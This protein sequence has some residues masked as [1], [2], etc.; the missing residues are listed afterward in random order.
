[1]AEIKTT[2]IWNG[3]KVDEYTD[4]DTGAMELRQSNQDEKGT[5]LAS[6]SNFEWKI[7]DSDLFLRLYNDR[8]PFTTK[9][10]KDEFDQL[11]YNMGIDLFNEDRANIL[12]DISNYNSVDEAK[13]RQT[14]FVQSTKIPGVQ[15]PVTKQVVN[16]NGT[17]TSGNPF[18]L[19]PTSNTRGGIPSNADFDLRPNV[20]P[21]LHKRLNI[22]TRGVDFSR[23]TGGGIMRYPEANLCE[24]GY[25][26]IQ[27]EG[28]EYS[29]SKRFEGG[30]GNGGGLIGDASERLGSSTG[31]VQLPMQGSLSETNSVDWGSDKLNSIMATLAGGGMEAIDRL[32]ELDLAGGV[33]AL[34]GA[35]RSAVG[36]A[37]NSDNTEYFLKAYFAGQAV[38]SNIVTRATGAVINP[39]MELLFNGPKLRDFGFSFRLT[40]RSDSEAKIIRRIIKFFKK[41][42]APSVGNQGVFLYTPNI[43]KLKYIHN[44]NGAQHPYLNKIKPCALVNFQVNYT[45]DNTYMTYE[46]GSLTSY[47]IS[48]TFSEIQ[49]IYQADIDESSDDMSY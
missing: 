35:F 16:K 19:D 45:P 27:I 12:N 30:S 18:G 41:N 7:E 17:V 31:V 22:Q 33:D 32:S 38:G 11:F 46:N 39:N 24:F 8:T 6:S 43:F 2:R 34:G 15:D 49:P 20:D 48:L 1:M 3:L 44:S 40:P 13:Q 47:N 25:D 29:T 4:T 36:K 42:M 14:S 37:L 28:H 23:S 9:L 10:T 5:L 21:N 26:Y